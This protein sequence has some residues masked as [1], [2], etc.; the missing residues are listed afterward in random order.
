MTHDA[1][2]DFTID[3]AEGAADMDVVRQLFS[4]YQAWLDVDLCF[5]DFA[6]ELESLPGAYAPSGGCLLLARRNGAVLGIVGFRPAGHGAP[7]EVCEMKRLYVRP[8]GRGAGIGRALCVE[9]MERARAAGY[10][11]MCLD[12]LE[13]LDGARAI[14]NDLGFRAI[15]AYY[16]NP[17]K[18]PIFMACDLS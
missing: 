8:Q 1:P 18:S 12:T 5:Q 17:L 11:S 7:G 4:E 2:R 10:A 6:A 13:K 3:L 15:E 9:I 14:Y 16:D